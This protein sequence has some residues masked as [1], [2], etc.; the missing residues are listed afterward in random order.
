MASR[1][2]ILHRGFEPEI[3]KF[4]SDQTSSLTAN[5]WGEDLKLFDD[6]S[7]AKKAALMVVSRYSQ[8][9]AQDGKTFSFKASSKIRL[10]KNTLLKLTEDDIRFY[11]I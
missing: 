7:E 6:F 8:S 5:L 9:D 10:L 3:Y 11:P 4:P 1:F 2:M